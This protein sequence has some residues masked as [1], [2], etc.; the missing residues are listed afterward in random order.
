MSDSVQNNVSNVAIQAAAIGAPVRSLTATSVASAIQS[1]SSKAPKIEESAVSESEIAHAVEKLNA[2][3]KE[4][5]I[6]LRFEK[7]ETLNRFIVEVVDQNTGERLIQV[8]NDEVIHAVEN[9]DRL[10][11]ILFSREA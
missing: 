10:R 4:R 8:P 11:G 1:V 9:I 3:L 7:N 2:V 6:S 5:D